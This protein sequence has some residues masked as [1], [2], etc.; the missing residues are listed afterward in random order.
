MADAARTGA[1]TALLR[2]VFTSDQRCAWVLAGLS[3]LLVRFYF[4]SGDISWSGDGSLHLTYAALAAAIFRDGSWPL[5]T[6]S[7]AS[8]SPFLQFYGFGFF[9][10]VGLCDLLVDDLNLTMKFVLAAGHVASG[11]SAWL[12]LRLAL[13][14]RAAAFVGGLAFVLTFWHTQ[15]VLIMGRLPLSLFYAL[16]PLPFYYVE[17]LRL[18]GKAGSSILLGALALAGLVFVHPGYAAWAMVFVTLYAGLRS[19]LWRRTRRALRHAV[20]SAGLIGLGL[21]LGAYLWLPMWLE[22]ATT[23][24]AHGID[25]A[26]VPDPGWQ[27]LLSWSNYRLLLLPL[28]E[29]ERHWYGGYLGLSLVVLAL[30]GLVALLRRARLPAAISAVAACLL[31]SLTLVFG[32]RWSLLQ[33]IEAV[34][35]F[36]AGRFLLFTS[37]FL[38]AT[39]AGGLRWIT[40]HHP[41]RTGRLKWVT[42]AVAVLLLDLGSTT[43]QQPYLSDRNFK[44]PPS[45]LAPQRT[46]A[47]T[48]EVHRPLALALL[49]WQTGKPTPQGIYDESSSSWQRFCLPWTEVIAPLI[50]DAP[51]LAS[52]RGSPLADVFFGGLRLLNVDRVFRFDGQAG[53]PLDVPQG[54]AS[55]AVVSSR[56]EPFDPADKDIRTALSAI[57]AQHP[58]GSDLTADQQRVAAVVRTMGITDGLASKRILSRQGVARDLETSPKALIEQHDVR[59]QSVTLRLRLSEDAFVRLAYSW[60]PNLQVHVDGEPV[61]TI[62]SAGGYMVVQM[63]AGTHDIELVPR[64]SGLRRGLL[65]L[66]VVVLLAGALYLGRQRLRH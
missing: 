28:A 36:N 41:H 39:A 56:L 29:Q 31:V 44:P 12:F 10:V 58:A 54:V 32:Y 4:A 23:G 59:Q 8:G 50:A 55:P 27:Q 34:Q 7:L 22:R 14:S 35:A 48:G 37:F 30:I 19:A 53:I 42:V 1:I 26:H 6:F 38:A 60:N 17:R 2:R 13:R 62:E 52:L 46:L 20:A 51:S 64:M 21:V 43:F 33:Q 49:L 16:L 5:W 24:L 40:G 18:P 45:S 47:I 66:N 3:L 57:V 15:Q 61:E 63:D 65:A 9:Y 25:L 11:L